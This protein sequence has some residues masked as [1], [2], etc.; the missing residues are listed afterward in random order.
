M[1]LVLGHRM[2][3]KRDRVE[4]DDVKLD[5]SNREVPFDV[6]NWRVVRPAI[7]TP[8]VMLFEPFSVAL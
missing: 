4:S 1:T 3:Q 6:G 8:S 5:V 7:G 2:T